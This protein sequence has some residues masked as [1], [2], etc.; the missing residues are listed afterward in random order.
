MGHSD[1]VEVIVYFKPSQCSNH[2]QTL[3][4]NC[5]WQNLLNSSDSGNFDESVG[6]GGCGESGGS[7]GCGESDEY[8]NSWPIKIFVCIIFVSFFIR[9]IRIF[10]C[11]IF[12]ANIFGYSF[13]SKFHI[14]HT[15]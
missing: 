10:V 13:I 12:Y 2:I 3:N 1:I 7:D 9:I 4:M 14:R 5:N 11:I 6:Y 15:S 8:G